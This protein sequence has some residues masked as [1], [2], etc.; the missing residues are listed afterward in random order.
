MHVVIQSTDPI[1]PASVTVCAF[2]SHR[3]AVEFS[4]QDREHRDAYFVPHAH[5]NPE[6][7]NLK[8]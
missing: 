7:G 8:S 4:E 6:D 1:P 5:V 3:E 2:D